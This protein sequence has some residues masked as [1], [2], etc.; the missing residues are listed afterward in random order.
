MSRLIYFYSGE[1]EG[2]GGGSGE[3]RRGGEEGRGGE[4][5]KNTLDHIINNQASAHITAIKN[6]KIEQLIASVEGVH[7]ELATSTKRHKEDSEALGLLST[8][9]AQLEEEHTKGTT[10]PVIADHVSHSSSFA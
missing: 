5:R 3:G 8:K 10:L 6:K 7:L 9:Y 1:R 4:Y 2:G